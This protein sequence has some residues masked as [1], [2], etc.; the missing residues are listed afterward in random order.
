MDDGRGRDGRVDVRRLLHIIHIPRPAVVEHRV[1]HVLAVERQQGVA[2]RAGVV[3]HGRLPLVAATGASSNGCL[4]TKCLLDGRLMA[5][6][7]H[8]YELRHGCVLLV[9]DCHALRVHVGTKDLHTSF[10]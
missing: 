10:K 6:E 4:K 2:E 7:V 1:G 8:E 3:Q 5:V 9:V